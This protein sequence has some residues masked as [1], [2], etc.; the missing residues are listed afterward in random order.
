MIQGYRLGESDF[1]GERFSAWSQNLRGC[2]DCLVLTRP[3]VIAEIHEK[4]L[5]V[6][7]DIIS[8]DSFNANAISLADYG[9][10]DYAYE[11]ARRSA[12]IA[13]EVADRFTARN[14][15]KP[16]FVAG[17]VGPTS[18]TSSIAIDVEN[19]ELLDEVK[20]NYI[21]TDSTEIGIYGGLYP[22]SPITTG[23]QITKCN[24][25]PRAS[26]DGKLSIEIE[27]KAGE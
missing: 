21:G 11:I 12:E 17:S 24:V 1:R 14:P 26:A 4:Y 10:S 20:S 18:K 16:R 8:T 2:N 27:V 25:A 3:D 6:G 22:Y 9:L 7:A 15:Q 5:S 19:L 23:P 13:R